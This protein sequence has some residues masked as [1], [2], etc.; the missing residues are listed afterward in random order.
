MKIAT[1][2]EC[3]R[4]IIPKKTA[5]KRHTQAAAVDYLPGAHY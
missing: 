5:A 1:G 3:R 2:D 4:W